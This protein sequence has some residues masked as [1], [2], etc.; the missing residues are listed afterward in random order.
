MGLMLAVVNTVVDDVQPENVQVTLITLFAVSSLGF[1]V[2]KSY[3]LNIVTFVVENLVDRWRVRIIGKMRHIDL[4]S[5]EHIGGERIALVLTRELQTLSNAGIAI[6]N[7]STTSIMLV[8]TSL[9]VARMSLLAFLAVILALAATVQLY[10]FSQARTREL[11]ARSVAA[12]DAFSRSFRHMLDGFREVKLSSRRSDDLYLNFVRQDSAEATEYKIAAA[13]RMTFGDNLTNLIFYSLV[14]YIVF[15]LPFSIGS[16]STAAKLINII[17]FCTGAIEL[18]IRGLPMLSHS[19]VAIA[20]LE[21]LEGEID[22]ALDRDE[23]AATE[24]PPEFQTIE[25]HNILYSYRTADG[26]RTF[27][28]GPIDFRFQRGEVLFIVGGNGSGK[29]TFLKLLARLYEPEHGFILWDGNA[30]GPDNVRDYRQLFSAIFSDFHLFDRL[31]GF[32]QV[33]G[34][35]VEGLI[36]EVRMAE[37]VT[38][39]GERFSTLDLSAGQRKRLALVVAKV[40]NRPIIIFDEWAAD[41]DPHFRRFFYETLIPQLK[42]AGKT[43]IAVNS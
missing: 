27:V 24:A 29:S 14:G 7:L 9:Y 41:Q 37:K 16:A 31:Y 25:A 26:G 20:T 21:R 6:L 34:A 35:D 43:V 19:A 2:S 15:I 32:R 39:S 30:V 33:A 18:V 38:F 42:A 23:Q 22:A 5:F 36:R 12:D 13:R 28:V 3:A 1:I 10:R 8:V 11:L 4:A 17:L 40:E